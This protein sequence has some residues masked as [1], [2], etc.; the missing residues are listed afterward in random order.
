M[1]FFKETRTKSE[2]DPHHKELP[3]FTVEHPSKNSLEHSLRKTF[4]PPPAPQTGFSQIKQ[5]LAN[6]WV[7]R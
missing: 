3:K 4:P 7:T 6:G 5:H 1:L 2:S